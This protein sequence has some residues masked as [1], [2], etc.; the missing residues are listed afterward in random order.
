MSNRLC[1]FCSAAVI[2]NGRCPKCK[3]SMPPRLRQRKTD[4]IDKRQFREAEKEARKD[5]YDIGDGPVGD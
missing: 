1:P 2:V 3:T 5:R 4:D